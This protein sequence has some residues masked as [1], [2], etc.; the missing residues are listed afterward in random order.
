VTL[1]PDWGVAILVCVP[2]LALGV[3][4][5]IF[6][7]PVASFLAKASR[8]LSYAHPAVPMAL[9]IVA[10]VFLIVVAGGG[11]VSAVISALSS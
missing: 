4:L 8:R 9:V 11:L 1:L 3:I 10:G 6:C 7:R 2:N 5:L